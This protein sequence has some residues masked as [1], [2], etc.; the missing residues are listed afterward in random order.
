[1]QLLEAARFRHLTGVNVGLEA[2][3]TDDVRA[4]LTAMG[5][6]IVSQPMGAY[7][8]AQA[9]I[10]LSKRCSAGCDPRRDGY[11]AGP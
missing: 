1:M 8:G 2:P 9:I 11:A 4:A 3:I 5:H 10:K 7:G 6:V